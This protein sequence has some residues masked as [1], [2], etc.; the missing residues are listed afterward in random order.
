MQREEQPEA[1]RPF[2]VLTGVIAVRSFVYFGMVTY[3]E[4]YYIRVLHASK[5]LGAGARRDPLVGVHRRERHARPDEHV[6]RHAGVLT[7]VEAVRVGEAVLE[8]HRRHPCLQEVGAEGQ[9]VLGRGEIVGRHRV[10]PE[11]APVALA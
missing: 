5:A 8:A 3:I 11:G 7:A 2:V 1:W 9:D 10:G 4:L 6:L